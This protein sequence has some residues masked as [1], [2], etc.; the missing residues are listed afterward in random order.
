MTS[1]SW[2]KAQVHWQKFGYKEKR[3]YSC[4]KA[5][6]ICA[7]EGHECNCPNGFFYYLKRDGDF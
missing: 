1:I 5:P 6:F 3:N 4:E 7:K 2:I